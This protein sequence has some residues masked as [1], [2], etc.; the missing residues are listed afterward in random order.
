[1]APAPAGY[2]RLAV[3]GAEVVA[4]EEHADAVREA[5]RVGTLYEYAA[6]HPRARSFRGRD[7]VWAAPLPDGHTDVVVRHSRHG[8]LLARFTGD[9]FLAP[10]RAPRE[11]A[12]ALRLAAA[13]VPTPEVVAYATYPAGPALRRADVATR[14][15]AGG[16]DLAS[17]FAEVVGVRPEGEGLTRALGAVQALL[18]RMYVCG[19]RHPDLNI[20]NVLLAPWESPAPVAYVLDV[21]RVAFHAPRSRAAWRANVRRLVRS[22]EKWRRRDQSAT[23]YVMVGFAEPWNEM[24]AGPAT[25]R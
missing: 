20:K 23:H 6:R 3:G 12:T 15:I 13:E 5:M 18:E 9:R 4:R 10:T 1:M 2:V 22:V 8:G 16:R 25:G 17:V 21:D 14:E 11:L 7:V 19:A 24:P